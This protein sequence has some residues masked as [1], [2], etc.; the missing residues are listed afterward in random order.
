MSSG[1]SLPHSIKIH[2]YVL[3]GSQRLIQEFTLK[4]EP[5]SYTVMVHPLRLI[6]IYLGTKLLLA[7]F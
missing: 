3:L 2:R 1:E 7:C 5:E 4:L 6:K